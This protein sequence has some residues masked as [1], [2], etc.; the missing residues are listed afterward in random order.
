M[1][2]QPGLKRAVFVDGVQ[3]TGRLVAHIRNTNAGERW[4]VRLPGGREVIGL[5]PRVDTPTKSPAPDLE[6]CDVYHMAARLDL[7]PGAVRRR[8]RSGGWG[9]LERCA[10]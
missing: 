5:V 9:L 8:A 1:R 4:A 10:V 6:W 7:S 3:H 2:L